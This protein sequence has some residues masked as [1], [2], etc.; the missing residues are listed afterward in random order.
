MYGTSIN[1]S[2]PDSSTGA[3]FSFRRCDR[4]S[5]SNKGRGYK[6]YIFQLLLQQGN[7]ILLHNN[8][9][10]VEILDNEIMVLAIDIDDNGFNG[11]VALDQYAFRGTEGLVSELLRTS[12]E[13]SGNADFLW[14]EAFF[15]FVCVLHLTGRDCS[16]WTVSAAD[17]RLKHR[18]FS[19]GGT[20]RW[21]IKA[22]MGGERIQIWRES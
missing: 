10:L 12:S 9:L 2:E 6:P 4:V 22:S 14:H 8:T 18:E 21:I 19:F 7:H 5:D 13:G 16:S 11:G 17:N 1:Y 15:V 3:M 20:V